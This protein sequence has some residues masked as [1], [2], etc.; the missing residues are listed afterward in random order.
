MNY[1]CCKKGS[2]I[3]K[4]SFVRG[5][6]IGAIIGAA[7]GAIIGP[8]MEGDAMKKISNIGKRASEFTGGMW[9]GLTGKR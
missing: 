3:L 6:A 2:G 8:Q 7:A 4:A 5:I 9:G 1:N